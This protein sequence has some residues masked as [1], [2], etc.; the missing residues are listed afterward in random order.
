MVK[1][2]GALGGG[3]HGREP[4]HRVR[5]SCLS[6]A[7]HGLQSETHARLQSRYGASI[8]TSQ[9]SEPSTLHSPTR[10]SFQRSARIW[11]HCVPGTAQRSAVTPKR[12]VE[13]G[14]LFLPYKW[15]CSPG[16]CPGPQWMLV[17]AQSP[18]RTPGLPAFPASHPAVW[19][20]ACRSWCERQKQLCQAPS[21]LP[22]AQGRAWVGGNW[23]VERWHERQGRLW[24]TGRGSGG[25]VGTGWEST[26][27]QPSLGLVS[28]H[29]WVAGH[30]WWPLSSSDGIGVIP[31]LVL[32]AW[33]PQGPRASASSSFSH[34]SWFLL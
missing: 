18:L 13:Q 7:A 25:Q 14:L 5:Q 4:W 29:C 9:P 24:G 16:T 2:E 32:A 3:R 34:V 12:P 8:S 6:T 23:D 21:S 31:G 11:P 33:K 27:H 17:A 1:A 15:G 19:S 26:P 10:P 20:R 22:G 28:P 30:P